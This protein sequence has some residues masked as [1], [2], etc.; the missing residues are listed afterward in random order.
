MAQ[1]RLFKLEI[2]KLVKQEMEERTVNIV[3][4]CLT[5]PELMG[6]GKKYRD[7]QDMIVDLERTV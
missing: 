4:N 6:E 5:V 7:F 1:Q 3:K 2:V